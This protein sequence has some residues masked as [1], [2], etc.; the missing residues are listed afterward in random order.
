MEESKAD[1]MNSDGNIYYSLINI[2]KRHWLHSL[3]VS[4]I[5]SHKKVCSSMIIII[6]I[7]TI[8][9]FSYLIGHEL[10]ISNRPRAIS[11]LLARLLPELYD[12]K[13]NY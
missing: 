9:K 6:I 5:F 11:E 2:L 8:S 10:V 4:S 7:I 13:S 1:C 3:G 12:T